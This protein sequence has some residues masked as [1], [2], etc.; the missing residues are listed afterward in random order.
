MCAYIPMSACCRL[1]MIGPPT[2]PTA[3][4][5]DQRRYIC[6]VCTISDKH[7]VIQH[8]HAQYCT[9]AKLSCSKEATHSSNL[10]IHYYK[11]SQCW[12]PGVTARNQHVHC[13]HVASQHQGIYMYYCRPQVYLMYRGASTRSGSLASVCVHK[14]AATGNGNS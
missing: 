3:H 14:N 11:W 8:I 6:S 1:F 12:D 13:V 5:Q 4:A 10:H 7:T 9:L 2:Q